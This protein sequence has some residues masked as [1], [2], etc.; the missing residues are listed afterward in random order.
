MQSR[1]IN[2]FRYFLEIGLKSPNLS[3]NGLKFARFSSKYAQNGHILWISSENKSHFMMHRRQKILDFE[4]ILPQI[5]QF[6]PKMGLNCLFFDKISPKWANFSWC[7]AVKC[8]FI[9]KIISPFRPK[10]AHSGLIWEILRL[11][12]HKF[13]HFHDKFS[14]NGLNLSDFWAKSEISRRLLIMKSAISWWC[15]VK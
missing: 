4:D 1:K 9:L 13:P 5:P 15:I 14:P 8:I 7:D 3:P 10:L 6:K 12:S 2:I 11:I